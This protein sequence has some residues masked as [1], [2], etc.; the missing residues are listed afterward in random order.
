MAKSIVMAFA[1]LF[2]GC[3]TFNPQDELSRA[4]NS[5]YQT[6]HAECDGREDESACK[7]LQDS[8]NTLVDA[9]DQYNRGIGK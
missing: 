5:I 9:I 6:Y 2:V 1:V 7:A 3:A 8:Y 4:A